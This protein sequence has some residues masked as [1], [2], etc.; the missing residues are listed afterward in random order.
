MLL[1]PPF[2]RLL[3]L[4]FM[5]LLGL[6]GCSA[7]D[8]YQN[9][10]STARSLPQIPE[11]R[12]QPVVRPRVT[13]QRSVAPVVRSRP[14][15]VSV[16]KPQKYTIRS[17][18]QKPVT[19]NRESVNREEQIAARERLKQQAKQAATVDIDPYASIPDSRSVNTKP[20]IRTTN[21]AKPSRMSPA[22]R[23]LMV[24]ARADI[25]VGRSNAAISK[26]ERGLRIDSSNS[27][28]W[29]FLAKAHYG[30]SAYEQTINMAKKSNSYAGDQK[31]IAE[32]WKLIK[33]AGERSGNAP[34]I[35]AALDYEKLNP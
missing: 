1:K 19:V 13:P 11:I 7:V 16:A 29:H 30:N 17:T 8:S 22:V 18:V 24:A 15:A 27:Q 21:T 25:A 5:L 35:K 31:L 33:K 23:S 20:D 32:N 2:I 10:R 28:L 3:S 4:L 26:L 34:A 12:R 14:P 6:S 9:P